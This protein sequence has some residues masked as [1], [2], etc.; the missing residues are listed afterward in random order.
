M[1]REARREDI[2]AI[3][4]LMESEPGFWQPGWS[5]ETLAGGI[6]S[7]GGL[8]FI[9]ENSSEIVGFVCAHDVG[10]R[11]YL[12]E[13]IVAERVRGCGVGKSLLEWVQTSLAQRG[14][15]TLIADVWHEAVPF[16]G[17]LGWEPP[18]AVLL[19]QKINIQS[20]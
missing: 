15:T 14:C 20:A 16:Y 4:R 9:W 12:S 3:R 5:N 8:A 10:F 11:A 18:D 17:S 2:P 6:D 13:L 19:R 7:A 1:I